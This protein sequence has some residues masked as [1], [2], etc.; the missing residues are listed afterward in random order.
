MGRTTGAKTD[1]IFADQ[2]ASD[3]KEPLNIGE[4]FPVSLI[5]SE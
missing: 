5:S 4:R 3:W 1:S 2:I